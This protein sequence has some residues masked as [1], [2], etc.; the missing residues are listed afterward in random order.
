MNA[1][2]TIIKGLKRLSEKANKNVSPFRIDGY[3]EAIKDAIHLIESISILKEKEVVNNKDK[4]PNQQPMND[5][6]KIAD[7]L[8]EKH[9]Q[10]LQEVYK[11]ESVNIYSSAGE[12]CAIQSVNHTINSLNAVIK[13]DKERYGITSRGASI[14]LDEQLELKKILE[15]RL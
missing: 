12:V 9:I 4:S 11:N 15:G 3:K 14:Q 1:K 10:A 8:V 5:L 7:G 13:H 6:E 2:R